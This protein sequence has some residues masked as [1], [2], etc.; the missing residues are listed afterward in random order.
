M[1]RR[2]VGRAKYLD[3]SRPLTVIMPLPGFSQTRATAS[4]RRPVAY[5]RPRSSIS[6]SRSGVSSTGGGTSVARPLRLRPSAGAASSAGAPSAGFSSV[7]ASAAA[8]AFASSLPPSVSSLRS[9]RSFFLVGHYAPT[10]FLRLRE[11]R[12]RTSGLSALVR[13]FGSGENRAG[14][15]SA[16]GPAARAGSSARRPFRARAR[17]ML[18]FEDALGAGFLDAA[19]M[20]GVLVIALVGFHACC[21]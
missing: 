8:S 1:T 10:L 6:C 15:A 14:C 11:A 18:A 5:A 12:S 7:L 16:G 19:R 21:R 17:G 4:L 13:M 2:S 9:D 20:A 3:W